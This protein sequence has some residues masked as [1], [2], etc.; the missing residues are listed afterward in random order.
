M[1]SIAALLMVIGTGIRI[2]DP[3]GIW[4]NCTWIFSV[5][6]AI[7]TVLAVEHNR[8]ILWVATIICAA[9]LAVFLTIGFVRLFRKFNRPT[10]K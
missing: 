8:E 10:K 7:F 4:S 6:T 3:K 5:F 9:V 2:E 1:S